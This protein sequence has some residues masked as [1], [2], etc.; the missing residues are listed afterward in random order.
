MEHYSVCSVGLRFLREKLHYK[1][2]VG[3]GHL[4]VLGVDSGT[5]SVENICRFALWSFVMYKAF[6]HLRCRSSGA[7]L[8]EDEVLGLMNQYLKDGVGGHAG[9]CN[10][11]ENCW[12]R[13]FRISDIDADTDIS[14]WSLD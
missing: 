4:I 9:A 7:S 8:A 11:L 6:N 10:F 14:D 5:Q 1:E 13:D 2:R 3:K 12:R